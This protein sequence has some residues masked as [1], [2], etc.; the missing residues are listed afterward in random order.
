MT[1]IRRLRASNQWRFFGVLL[2]A[3]RRL[4][5]LWWSVLVLRGLLPAVF[6][7]AMGALVGA[8]QSGSPLTL[9]LS[10][11]GTIFVLLQILPPLHQAIG[12]NLGSRTAAW[13]YD[14][15]TQ[16]CV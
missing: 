10:L 2:K 1:A 11:T 5:V 7:I 14:E 9:T 6:A 16:A 8:V 12:Q 3:D 4:A 13:L 15:L